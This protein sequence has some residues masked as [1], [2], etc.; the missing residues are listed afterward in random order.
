M[1]TQ[2]RRCTTQN[3][4]NAGTSGR[5]GGPCCEFEVEVGAEPERAKVVVR[6]DDS[7]EERGRGNFACGPSQN[8]ETRTQGPDFG[9]G[10][11]MANQR[12]MLGILGHDVHCRCVVEACTA[13]SRTT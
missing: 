13:S 11:D 5:A 8:V 3:E 2:G 9:Y 1:E 6:F 10:G 12:A 4:H 7:N